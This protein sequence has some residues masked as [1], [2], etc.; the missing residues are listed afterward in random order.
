MTFDEVVSGLG[1]TIQPGSRALDVGCGKGAFA[2]RLA[3][4]LGITVRGIDID[5]ANVVEAEARAHRLGLEGQVA[6]E[7]IDF[8]E[9]AL[10][11]TSQVFE[12]IYALD[13]LQHC[14]DLRVCFE[15]LS[16]KL[17]SEGTFLATVWCFEGPATDLAIQLGSESSY[18]L[19][20]LQDAVEGNGWASLR[21]STS[22]RFTERCIGSLRSLGANA[23]LFQETV[24]RTA[25]R[26][27]LALERKTVLAAKAGHLRQAVIRASRVKTK[28]MALH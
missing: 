15:R 28:A 19:R 2:C 14:R 25:Y 26:E 12:I 22:E 1:A 4:E 16:N 6:F 13:S 27:R 7:T 8:N 23:L 5:R 11:S 9:P 20:A 18:D 24:G 21:V 17:S 3:A 10:F